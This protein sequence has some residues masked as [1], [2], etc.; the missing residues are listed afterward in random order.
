[1]KI[2]VGGIIVSLFALDLA[3]VASAQTNNSYPM[4]MSVKPAAAQIGQTTEHEVSARYILSG[5]DQVIVAGDAVK[6]EIV[7][8]EKSDKDPK[9][10]PKPGRRRGR[11]QRNASKIK[12]RFTVAADAVPGV[13]DFRIITPHGA[14]TV[15]QIVVARDFRIPSCVS[16]SGF[17][18][19]SCC[20]EGEPVSSSEK[21]SSNT[22]P[23]SSSESAPSGRMNVRAADRATSS[24]RSPQA[25]KFPAA[26]KAATALKVEWDAGPYATLGSADLLREYKKLA[27]ST[28]ESSARMVC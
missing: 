10:E 19:A 3:S 6:G 12:V 17:T 26:V 16:S 2:T 28:A 11:G 14:S 23:A 25:E 4:L 13:R 5:A 9:E 21:R 20:A 7:P 18:L 22:C 15:G 1:M 8:E 24:Q 27:Q